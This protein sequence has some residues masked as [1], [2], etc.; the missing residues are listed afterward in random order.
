MP[1]GSEG[2]ASQ[3]GWGDRPLGPRPS[4][5]TPPPAAAGRPDSSPLWPQIQ[6]LGLFP[7]HGVMMKITVPIA[8][9]GG[10]RLLMLR[11]FLTD[12]VPCPREPP[13]GRGPVGDRPTPR[14]SPSPQTSA[15]PPRPRASR[16]FSGERRRESTSGLLSVP[17]LVVRLVVCGPRAGE[18]VL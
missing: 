15:P 6:N 12:Q 5:P 1:G 7:I 18:H 8:T 11:D 16:A 13:Q 4:P 2:P 14:G 10:N 3:P 17:G 9:R